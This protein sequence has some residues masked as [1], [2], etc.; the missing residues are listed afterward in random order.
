MRSA[1][2]PRAESNFRWFNTRL[3]NHP[4][5]DGEY[6]VEF[7]YREVLSKDSLLEAVSFYLVQAPKQEAGPDRP[8]RPAFTLFPR[9]HQ[10]R[11]VERTCTE[12][13]DH[14][15]ENDNLEGGDLRS[16]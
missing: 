8:E 2:Y 3:S 6:P 7:L 15:V 14:F 5:T 9:Y 4:E 12:V 16:A 1:T 13:V 10:R 11:C